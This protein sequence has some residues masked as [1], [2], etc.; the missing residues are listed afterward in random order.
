MLALAFIADLTLRPDRG[1]IAMPQQSFFCLLPCGSESLR[2]LLSNILLFV[3]LGWTLSYRLRPYPVIAVS[4]LITVTIEAL[5][6]SVIAGRDSSLRDILSNTS[7]AAV[8][9]WM[10][11]NCATLRWPERRLSS[12]LGLAYSIAWFVL[13]TLTAAATRTAPTDRQWFGSWTPER[14]G[15]RPF[16]G[17]LLSVSLDGVVPEQGPIPNAEPL[18]ARLGR[19]S[20]NLTARLVWGGTVFGRASIFDLV[21]DQHVEQIFLGQYHNVLWLRVRTRFDRWQM[22]GLTVRLRR[23][24]KWKL[25]DTITVN[26]GISERAVVIQAV[27]ASDTAGIRVPLTAGLGWNAMAPW[28]QPNS[29]NWYYNAAW[30][31]LLAGPLGY[32]FGRW[33]PAAGL[34]AGVTAMSIGLV[35]GPMIGESAMTLRVE[36]IG[37]FCGL[38]SGWL[39]GVISRRHQPESIGERT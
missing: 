28:L 9:V 10:F 7:G 6:Y 15:Y 23:E 38:S 27:G 14:A 21:D 25:G 22:R 17:Q 31:A 19:D 11:H 16:T 20:F 29:D 13:L 39:G 1:P 3:P 32:W 2:D 18:R 26:A 34:A 4:L 37:A 8:G 12:R 30:L 33:S 35:L 36:W 5:Q 24:P